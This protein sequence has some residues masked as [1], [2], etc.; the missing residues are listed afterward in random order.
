MITVADVKSAVK[1]KQKL[2]CV[3][4]TA[5]MLDALAAAR[6]DSDVSAAP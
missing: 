1:S 6:A 5:V 4:E 3:H 2:A